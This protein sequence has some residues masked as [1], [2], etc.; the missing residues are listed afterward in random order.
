MS[1][2]N[3]APFTALPLNQKRKAELQAFASAMGLNSNATVPVLR[4]DIQKHLHDH[5]ELADDPK[6]S[7]LLTSRSGGVKTSAHKAAEEGLGGPITPE[8][9]TGA[10]CTLIDKKV[11]TDPP[12]QLAKLSLS[13]RTPI[14]TGSAGH[15][16]DRELMLSLLK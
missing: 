16:D 4:S 12:G 8:V 1:Q 10:N 15:A 3:T 9:V 2:I 6:Y 5:P 11:K 14:D 7:S 13:D